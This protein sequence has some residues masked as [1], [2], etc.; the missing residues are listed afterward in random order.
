MSTAPATDPITLEIIASGLQATG[1]QMFAALRKTAMSA[2]IYEVLDAGTAITNATGDLVSSG[3]G[4]PTFV[5]VLDRAVKCIREL[6][7]A[8]EIRPGDV[9]L[10][11]DPAYGGVTHLNDVVVAL[12]V[13]ADDELVAWTANIAH[14]ND[15]GGM[16]PGS[17]STDAREIFQEGLRL[18]AVK[19]LEG[20]TPVRAVFDILRANS[21]LPDFLYGDLWAGIAAAR[22]GERRILEL[23]QR[24]GRPTFDHAVASELAY[25][26][27]VARRGLRE[28]PRGR[29][30]LEEGQ[31]DGAVY[32]VTVEIRDGEF[33]VDLRNNPDQDMGPSNLSRDGATIAAQMALMN[34]IG[35]QGPVNAGHLR[36]LTVLTRP[37][38]VF[39]PGPTAAC[40]LYY[41]VRIGLYDLILR[42]LAP[43]L[44]ERLPAGSFASIC[45]TFIGGSHPE[46]GRHFTIV[47]PQV[48]GWGAS[49]GR[50]GN[51]A[52]FSPVHGDTFNCPAEVA[53]GRYGLYVEQLALSAAPGGAG[54]HR[55]GRGIVLDYRVRSDGC[56]LTCV[57]RR[58]RHPPWSLSGGDPGSFNYVEVV[59]D[60]GTLERHR[61]VT[62]LPLSAGDVIRIHTANGGGFG[63]PRRRAGERVRED[64][65]DGYVSITEAREVY[66]LLE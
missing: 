58:S 59:R 15:V 46:T 44:A 63:D 45:G 62:A 60:D 14:W 37:G 12:P 65:R 2:I 26:E 19:L 27:E 41:E 24:Y 51:S 21:R 17:I 18:P 9:F 34:V 57:Y 22:V 31:D 23:I 30:Q 16:A 64:V 11:N 61:A 40:G 52:Q 48:G 1:E 3:A 53:E 29:F 25:G 55:G 33:L 13:F 28:L 56:F 7:R 42:C 4:I 32:A 66:G 47:E 8:E 39:D 6:H 43:H 20:G 50:D 49:G 10:T 36:P 54:E 5:A 35:L 38:S